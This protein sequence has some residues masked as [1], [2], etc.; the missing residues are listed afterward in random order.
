MSSNLDPARYALNAEWNAI[1]QVKNYLHVEHQQPNDRATIVDARR[2]RLPPARRFRR[3]PLSP[4]RSGWPLAV[5]GDVLVQ[6][7]LFADLET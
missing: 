1:N 6:V 7:Q 4:V 2:D 3:T 5:A